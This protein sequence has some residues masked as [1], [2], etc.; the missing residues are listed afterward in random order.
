MQNVVMAIALAVTPLAAQ[1][2]NHPTPGI[3]R[4]KEAK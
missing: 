4:T 1:W 3:P 2:I